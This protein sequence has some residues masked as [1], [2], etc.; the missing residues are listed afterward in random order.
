[1]KIALN[2]ANG[3]VAS[4]L[5]EKF[6][7]FVVIKRDDSEEETLQKLEEVDAVFNLAGSPNAMVFK[8]K[9]DNG[10]YKN[11]VLTRKRESSA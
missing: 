5:K 2:G 7:D 9:D 6:T 10:F 4:Y 11:R 8:I 1:M 3:F